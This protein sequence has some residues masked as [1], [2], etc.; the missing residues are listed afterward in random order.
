MVHSVCGIVL[1]LGRIIT[2]EFNICFIMLFVL[3]VAIGCF[4]L[5]QSYSLEGVLKLNTVKPLKMD[6]DIDG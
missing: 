2:G 4:R 5:I 1:N 6:I 3:K